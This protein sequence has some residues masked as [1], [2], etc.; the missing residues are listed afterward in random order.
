MDAIR[1]LM[2]LRPRKDGPQD[3]LLIYG[4]VDD[5]ATLTNPNEGIPC[6]VKTKIE[7]SPVWRRFPAQRAKADAPRT[8]Q[9]PKS[10]VDDGDDLSVA[11]RPGAE[12]SSLID[13]AME[14]E[15]QD[16]GEEEI[17]EEED[18]P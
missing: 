14:H 12:L 6:L 16:T 5:A 4:P 7:L 2:T 18:L 1:C 3:P 10:D 15:K 13:D 9:V 8:F 17:S 11:F